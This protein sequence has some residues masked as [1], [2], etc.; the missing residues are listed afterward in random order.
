MLKP[1]RLQRLAWAQEALLNLSWVSSWG[2]QGHVQNK[3]SLT[4]NPHP[5]SVLLPK[6][7][8]GEPALGT[9]WNI[10]VKPLLL[11]DNWHWSVCRQHSFGAKFCCSHNLFT[12]RTKYC[13]DQNYSGSGKMFPGINSEKLLFFLMQEGPCL[14]LII[15]SSN[16]QA[17]LLLQDKLLES[18]WKQLIPVK[19][20]ENYW[21]R[22]FQN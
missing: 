1:Q 3:R 21:T 18:V 2:R 5:Y 15:V 10:V 17:L 4:T 7:H 16:F 6:Q 8:S 12:P 11:C 22:P 19:G 20:L 9:P 14:E 13:R